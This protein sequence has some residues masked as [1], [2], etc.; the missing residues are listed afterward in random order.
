MKT[1]R[2]KPVIR[3]KIITERYSDSFEEKINQLMEKY[4]FEDF[5][6]SVT[7][8]E[9]SDNSIVYVAAILISEKED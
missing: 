3:W 8:H 7:L 6:F 4:N 1:F 2:G 9:D 5:Q